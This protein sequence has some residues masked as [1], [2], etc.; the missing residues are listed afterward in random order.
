LDSRFETSRRCQGTKRELADLALARI[1]GGNMI[2]P[3]VSWWRLLG[4]GEGH[5]ALR[6]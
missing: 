6:C 4:R 1:I 2:R 5:H 3:D